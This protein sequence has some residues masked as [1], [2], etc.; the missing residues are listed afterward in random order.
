MNKFLLSSLV[1]IFSTFA[2]ASDRSCWQDILEDQ[3]LHP[4]IEAPSICVI[5]NAEGSI[6]T[7]CGQKHSKHSDMFSKYMEYH[8]EYF[9]TFEK[10]QNA[11]SKGEKAELSTNIQI[12]ERD[13]MLY[14]YRAEL[15]VVLGNVGRAVRI[16]ADKGEL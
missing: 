6:E 1:L 13:W 3:N 11:T 5:E 8:N 12:I 16:C 15:E 2:N 14:G 9:V 7:L 10:L 4:S